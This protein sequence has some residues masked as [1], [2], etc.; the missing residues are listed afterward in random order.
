METII[1]PW[2]MAYITGKKPDGCI[3]CKSSIRS[4]ELILFEGETAFIM[5]NRYPYTCGHLMII[6]TR[7]VSVLEDLSAEESSEIFRLVGVSIRILKKAMQPDGMNIGMNL[8]RAA[9]A[10]VDD[11]IHM[12]I[13][14]RWS[15][16]TNFLSVVGDVRVIPEDVS[17]TWERLVPYYRKYLSGE[18][19]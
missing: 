2:R 19:I 7:H 10:G 18:P 11:H 5:M 8:G 3:F 9:G 13:V 12:H 6:P 16:D 14:P 17:E 15:G 4:E 1:S